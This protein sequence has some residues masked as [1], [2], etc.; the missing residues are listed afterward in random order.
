MYRIKEILYGGYQDSISAIKSFWA[1][2]VL[3]SV[4]FTA[5]FFIYSLFIQKPPKLEITTLFFFAVVFLQVINV[6]K[7]LLNIK[8]RYYYR[9]SHPQIVVVTENRDLIYTK[10]GGFPFSS[11]ISNKSINSVQVT[12]NIYQRLSNPLKIYPRGNVEIT[13]QQEGEIDLFQG[14]LLPV[15]LKKRLISK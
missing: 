13:R 5:S 4:F 11:K 14:I 15:E 3:I 6:V 9:F 8:N 7:K 1:I 10:A 12:Y 2:I